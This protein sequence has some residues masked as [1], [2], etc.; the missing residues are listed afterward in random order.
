MTDFASIRASTR[1]SV[2]P[3]E[4]VVINGRTPTH[5]DGGPAWNDG[6]K[7]ATPVQHTDGKNDGKDIGR[8]R[9]ITY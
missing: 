7:A 1:K 4:P 6:L 5:S 3:A 9:V 2:K 8:G